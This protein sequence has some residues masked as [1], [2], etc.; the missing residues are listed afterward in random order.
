MRGEDLTSGALFSYVDVEARIPAQH[1]LRAMR[2]L[3]NAALAELDARFSAL[4]EGIGRPSIPPER[5]LRA[6]L[7]QLF[8]S[9]RS[10]RQLVERLEFDMLFRWFVGLMIDEKVFDASTFSKNRDRLLTD[11][12]AQEFLSSLLGLPEVKG[13]LSAEHFSVDGTVLKAWA[14]MKSFRPRDGSDEGPGIGPGDPPQ[15]G[16][17]REV[18][19][20]KTKRSNAT[21]AST[22]DKDARLYRKG[23]GQESRLAYLGHALMENRNG[24]VAAAEATLATRNGRARGGGGFQRAL[25]QGSNARRRQGL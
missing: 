6:S 1:P 11:A 25:A 12:L 23:A 7:L 2:R 19:F 14:S 4:Y 21:H 10:E 13:L 18:D 22:T 9:I 5:L 3:T 17:N 20:R 16:R 24:L 8:Y 15:P